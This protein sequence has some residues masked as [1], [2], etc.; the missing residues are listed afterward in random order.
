[1]TKLAAWVRH[2][3]QASRRRVVGVSWAIVLG[4]VFLA[5]LYRADARHAQGHGDWLWFH[6]AWDTARR[7]L[8]QFH[9]PLYWNPYYCGG[10]FGL[11]NPQS[12]AL[13]P[14]LLL[15]SPFSTAVGLKLFLSLHVALGAWGMWE[16]ARALAPRAGGLGALLAA[17]AFACSGSMGFH[18]NGQISMANF[19]LYPWVFLG[20]VAG[21][22]RPLAAFGAGAVL[23]V[24][25]LDNGVYAAALGAVGASLFAAVDLVFVQKSR[26][27]RLSSVRAL[28]IASSAA[29]G[30]SAVRLLPIAHVMRAFPRPIASDD[31]IPLS[32]VPRMLLERHTTETQLWD[33]AA[34][35]LTYRWW[36]EYGNYLGGMGLALVVAAWITTGRRLL[37]RERLVALGLF[38]LLLG[39]HGSFSPFGVLRHIPPFGGLRVPTRYWPLV[40]LFAV[41]PLSVFVHR[42]IRRIRALGR[43]AVR[44]AAGVS[45]TLVCVGVVGDWVWSNGIAVHEGAMVRPPPPADQPFVSFHQVLGSAWPMTDYPPRN[46]GTLRCFDEVRVPPAP[47][48]RAS[49]PSEV[50]AVPAQG[51]TTTITRWTPN[52]VEVQVDARSSAADLVAIVYNQTLYRGWVT[53]PGP[54]L[55]IAGLVATN[56]ARGEHRVTFRFRPEGFSL[57]LLI[58]LCTSFVGLLLAARERRSA[59]YTNG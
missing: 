23:A 51:T 11:A 46:Q 16:L 12:F 14:S 58:S 17:A 41:L 38:A 50:F 8:L 32:F 7:S 42:A 26:S 53:E 6:F 20:L 5:P 2:V 34:L 55:P 49:L 44:A 30:L 35:G 24:M 4:A 10:S 3:D 1:M 40:T 48:L 52:E 21:R 22:T 25:V 13:S 56:V 19:E 39:D 31:S 33:N 18:M 59:R 47:G 27:D 45:F 54:P 37:L 15:L 28:A 43:P 57:G 36:G 29:V 9:E